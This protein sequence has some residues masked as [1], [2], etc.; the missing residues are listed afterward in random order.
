[1]SGGSRGQGMWGRGLIGKEEGKKE[2]KG[3][4]Q[5]GNDSVREEGK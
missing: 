1:M 2:D 4:Q 3:V 5:R